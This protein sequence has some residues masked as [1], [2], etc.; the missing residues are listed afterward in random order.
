MGKKLIESRGRMVARSGRDMG[1][2]GVEV[3]EL[4][5]ETMYF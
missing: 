3:A 4:E 1:A 5:G 2:D